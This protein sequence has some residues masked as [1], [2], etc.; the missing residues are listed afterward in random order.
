MRHG[1]EKGFVFDVIVRRDANQTPFGE[2]VIVTGKAGERGTFNILE[3][4]SATDTKASHD[5]VVDTIERLANRG[6]GFGQR[7]EGLIAQTSKDT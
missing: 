3:Q 4:M 2:L 1:I 5:V 6:I 7:E